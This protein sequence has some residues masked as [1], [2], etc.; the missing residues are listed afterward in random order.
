VLTTVPGDAARVDLDA[1]PL[2]E[3]DNA[4]RGCLV[5]ARD[6]LD[7]E[8]AFTSESI[9]G[10]LLHRAV[11]DRGESFSVELGTGSAPDG[12]GN[13][14]AC[15]TVP[16]RLSDG[17]A[18]GTLRCAG[19]GCDRSRHGDHAASLRLL[20]QMIANQLERRETESVTWRARIATTGAQALLAALEARDGYTKTHSEA[21]VELAGTTSERLGLQPAA[22]DEVRQ[23]ALLHDLGKIALPDPILA[24]TD[25]LTEDEW[26]LVKQHSATGARIVEQVD[27]L[28]HLAPAIRA[29]H[30]RWDGRGYPDGLR[31]EAIP[32]ASRIVFLCD[33]YHAMV[34]DRPYRA[35]LPVE[36]ALREIAFGSA[37]QFCP[38]CVDALTAAA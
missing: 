11:G 38:H 27:G 23:V 28:S 22:I 14:S 26:E 20:G 12:L 4:V 19:G 31:G 5:A 34:S 1:M 37:T 21:V 9:Q 35:A 24:K 6:H 30:E 10:R 33:A 25:P 7:M 13:C 2:D 29:G 8:L 32:L 18:Y 15:A 17:R 36:T 16:L 3:L